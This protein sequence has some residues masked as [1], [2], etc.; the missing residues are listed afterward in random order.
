M[1]KLNALRDSINRTH[2]MRIRTHDQ[3][4]AELVSP[5]VSDRTGELPAVCAVTTNHPTGFHAVDTS[6]GGSFFLGKCR[7]TNSILHG[8]DVRGDELK[9]QGSVVINEGNEI[10]LE[11]DEEILIDNSHLVKTLIHNN[12]HDL[13]SPDSFTI[14]DTVACHYA[15]IHGSISSGV[16]YG[17]FSTVDLTTVSE[18]SIGAY[19]YVQTGRLNGETV[20]PGTILVHVL[21][22][23]EFTYR[24]DLD[25]L[26]RYI[27]LDNSSTP[28]GELID[29]MESYEGD[30]HALFADR[31]PAHGL[32]IPESSSVDQYALIR[33]TTHIGNNVL[34]AQRAYL[35]NARLGNGANAQENCYLI[36][37]KLAGN[38]VTAHGGKVMAADIEPGVFVGF[39]SFL[40]GRNDARLRVGEEA[41]IMPHTIIDSE[42]PLTIPANHVVWGLIQNAEDLAVHCLSIADVATV[43]GEINLGRMTF[44]GDGST[45]INA[46]QARVQHIL[47]ENGAFFDG[48]TKHGHAQK[49]KSI[50]YK[51]L[52]PNRGGSAA[53]MHPDI[54]IKK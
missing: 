36:N 13:E 52:P 27:R 39:N 44:T 47:A 7:V 2:Q 28:S 16:F 40:R 5:P 6:L 11:Q 51:E 1:D 41:I 23:F 15:N 54:E 10:R 26:Q 22:A 35:E 48:H 50:D 53:M 19:S 4:R 32:P 12:S 20:E 9:R 3:D 34:V 45:L 42:S 38:N 29:F 37:T 24:F 25:R 17:P 31:K 18:S 30:V 43:N 8:C 33:P 46:F 21:G 14:Q 49:N